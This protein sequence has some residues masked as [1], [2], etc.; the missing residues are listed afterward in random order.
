[1]Q[2]SVIVVGAGPGGLSTAMRL[3]HQG[4]SVQ[5]F[6]A[7]DKVGGRTRGLKIGSYDFDTGPTILQVPRVYEE[8]F[9]ESGLDFSNYINLKKLEPN[10]RLRFWDD[11]QLDLTSD[12]EAF[13]VQLRNIRPDLPQAFDRWYLE[14]IRKNKKGY[15][16]YIGSPVRTPL[17][18]LRP[19]EIVSALSFRPWE[20]LYQHLWR[21]F[22]DER[23]VYALS[24]PSKYLGMHPTVCSSIFSLIPFLEFADGVWH[25]EGGFRALMRAMANGAKDLGT[26]IHLNCSVRQVLVENGQ[27]CGVELT[28][29]ERI[30]ADAVII[31]ADFGYGVRHLLPKSSRGRYGDKKLKSMRF[32]CSTFML[33]LGIDCRYENLPHHQLYL[34]EHIRRRDRPWIDDSVLDEQ[35]PSFYVCN[36]TIVDPSNAPTG[37]ST[38]YVLVPIPNTAHGVDW[39][40]KQQFYRDFTIKRLSLLGF[41]NIEHHIKKEAC[42]TSETWQNEYRVH[43]GAVFNLSHSWN[44][45]GPF[46]PPI[47]SEDLKSLYWIG[48]AVHPGSGLLT[49]LEAARN[50]AFFIKQDLGK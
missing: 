46:R 13:K 44:Q 29:G 39:K 4:Y 41:E 36:P 30:K 40:Q 49:I 12:L 2:K 48:G 35:N 26:K 17:G 43:L 28:N 27:A 3:A 18:Y 7:A 34:S 24:Y 19:K 21:F 10:V 22:K 6:E 42:Y 1:M 14:H 9:A 45:L 15:K 20:S 31:N 16:P 37:H 50:A 32:S 47:R 8:L 23:I 25:P 11:S 5:I 33:Y 38:L